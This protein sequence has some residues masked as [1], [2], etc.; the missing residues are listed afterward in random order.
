MPRART[1]PTRLA[2]AWNAR[3]VGSSPTPVELDSRGPSLGGALSYC[4]FQ[5][6]D[7]VAWKLEVQRR[8]DV[9]GRSGVAGERSLK[10]NADANGRH[11]VW[12]GLEGDLMLSTTAQG[13][14]WQLRVD[15][16][17]TFDGSIWEDPSKPSQR[18][19]TPTNLIAAG[20]GSPFI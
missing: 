5:P 8:M 19:I 2:L 11:S 6:S 20:I 16:A 15:D 13:S 7:P 9:S 17:G 4:F 18:H 10:E 3:W 14:F 1:S 12:N